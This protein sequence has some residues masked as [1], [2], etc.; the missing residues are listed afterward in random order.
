MHKLNIVT[1]EDNYIAPKTRRCSCI[2]EQHSPYK[3][4]YVWSENGFWHMVHKDSATST[5]RLAGTSEEWGL[6]DA[7][8][9]KLRENIRELNT[10]TLHTLTGGE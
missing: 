9:Q 1:V 6:C 5:S 10:Q 7:C 8:A 2:D 3:V 4:Y